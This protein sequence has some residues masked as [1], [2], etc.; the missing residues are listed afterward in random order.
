MCVLAPQNAKMVIPDFL[1]ALYQYTDNAVNGNTNQLYN[2][3]V[4]ATKSFMRMVKCKVRC[5]LL[6][7]LYRMKLATSN[8]ESQTRKLCVNGNN[9][10]FKSTVVDKVKAIVM[11]EKV[12]DAYAEYRKSTSVN[13]KVWRESK[14]LITGNLRRRY[15]VEWKKF[16]GEF[17]KQQSEDAKRKIDWLK[18][19]WRREVQ[20]P[21]EYQGIKICRDDGEEFPPEFSSEPRLYGEIALNDDEKTALTLPP[22]FALL[23]RVN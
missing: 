2:A 15:M 12:N 7:S 13:N 17:K 8:V 1:Q 10:V 5:S 6:K 20:V 4:R 14:V 16:M 23:E 3:M 11:R 19:K 18:T 22:K 21:H 9:E